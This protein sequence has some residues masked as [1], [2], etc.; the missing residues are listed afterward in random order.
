MIKIELEGEEAR[1]FETLKRASG[2]KRNDVLL[3]ALIN[4][5]SEAIRR[6]KRE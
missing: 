3:K 1:R 2:F 6:G 4:S 5:E